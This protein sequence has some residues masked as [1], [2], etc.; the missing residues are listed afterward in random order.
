MR[1]FAPS[2][3]RVA[4]ANR[5]ASRRVL[6]GRAKS[7]MRAGE[8]PAFCFGVEALG[9]GRVK[10]TS[11]GTAANPA[12]VRAFRSCGVATT[13]RHGAPALC[14]ADT[15]SQPETRIGGP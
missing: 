12:G 8:K 3:K 9:T 4:I 1:S 2:S 14:S 5:N 13:R 6:P 15:E 11:E 7:E 10:P